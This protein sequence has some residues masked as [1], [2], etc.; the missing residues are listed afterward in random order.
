MYPVLFIHPQ[1]IFVSK[2]DKQSIIYSYPML[3]GVVRG[4]DAVALFY[5]GSKPEEFC[6]IH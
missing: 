5:A 4:T 3:F 6:Q 2:V 1:Y